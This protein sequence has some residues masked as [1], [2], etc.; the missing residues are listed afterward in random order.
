ML[1]VANLLL[2]NLTRT[3]P[4]A[5]AQNKRHTDYWFVSSRSPQE[6]QYFKEEI[7]KEFPGKSDDTIAAAIAACKRVINPSEGRAKLAACVKKKLSG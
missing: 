4:M 7:R 5:D 6:Y 2:G 1:P 3:E